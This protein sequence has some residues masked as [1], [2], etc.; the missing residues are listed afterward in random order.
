MKILVCPLN[1]GLGHATRCIPL[2]RQ[3]VEDGHE[4][5]IVAD[6][7]PL[8]LL[9]DVFP[10]LRTIRFSSYRISYSPGK[11]QVVAMLKSLPNIVYGIFREHLWLRKLLE[12]EHFDRVV[13]DNRFG[14]WSRRAESVYITHQLRV[15][16]PRPFGWLEPLNV[17]LHR[18]FIN[19]YT[20]CWIPD[21]EGPENLSA[22]L[23]HGLKLPS[24]CR[25][26]GPL[27]RFQGFRE[28]ETT[29]ENY[30]WVMIISGPEPQRT[31]FEA[32]MTAKAHEG[33]AK[34]L[35]VR[36]LPGSNEPRQQSGNLTIVNHLADAALAT[37]LIHCSHIF[38][39]SGYSTIMDLHALGCLHKAVF[40][41]TPGQTEQEYLAGYYQKKT[42]EVSSRGC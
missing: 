2:I 28:A 7:H 19:R 30:D 42:A 18:V 4:V 14:M 11:S 40:I 5:V 13:S 34:T 6:G 38:C 15:K 17:L 36:G 3:W 16:M 24:H 32:A 37:A 29:T 26:I 31:L 10:E 8:A 39:R 21:Y 35:L 20:Q 33:T 25:Y 12:K 9:R 1:W 41:P 27:S 23:S 22:E